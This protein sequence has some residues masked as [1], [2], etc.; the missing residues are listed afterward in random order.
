MRT[1]TKYQIGQRSLLNI[2]TPE[3]AIADAGEVCEPLAFPLAGCLTLMG[4]CARAHASDRPS[5]TPRRYQAVAPGPEASSA[6]T[7]C[8][9]VAGEVPGLEQLEVAATAHLAQSF[10]R[11]A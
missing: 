2:N 10:A 6:P 3:P 1:F 9:R 7:R 11:P 8:R 4:A 5:M